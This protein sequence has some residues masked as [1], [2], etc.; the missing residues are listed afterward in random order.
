MADDRSR[1]LTGAVPAAGPA[2]DRSRKLTGAVPAGDRNRKLTTPPAV[3]PAPAPQGQA[4]RDPRSSV[5]VPVRYRYQSFIQFIETQSMNIS[6]SGMFLVADESI[7]VGTT[8]DFELSLADGFALM[9][10]K[11]EVV[12]VSTA[13]RGLGIRFRQLDEPSRKL[14][15]R[16]LHINAQEGKQPTVSLDFQEQQ[17]SAAASLAGLKGATRL[18]AGVRFSGR[19]LAVQINTGTVG[20]FTNNPLLNIRLGG[21]VVPG[22]EDVALGT[23]YS[24]TINDFNGAALWT[25]KGK[26]VAKHEMRLG[27]RLLEIPK[28]VLARLQ[29]EVT[30]LAPSTK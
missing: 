28:E 30:K 15:D 14:L 9:R 18:S 13:P 2:D 12:R 27:I 24:V 7:A 21:F 22:D 26:V 1:K 4:G 23:V 29:A 25:G 17:P 20:Y 5:V 10:G 16:I 19:D 6:R 3:T 8:I 11:G